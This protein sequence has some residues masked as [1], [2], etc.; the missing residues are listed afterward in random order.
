MKGL[1]KHRNMCRIWK[2]SAND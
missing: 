2:S 1:W